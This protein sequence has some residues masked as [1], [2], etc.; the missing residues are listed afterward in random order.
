MNLGQLSMFLEVVR[1]GSLS[2]AARR[3]NLTQPAVTRKMQRL[4]KELGIALFERGEGHQVALTSMGRD[5]LAF[6]EKVIQDF[7]TLQESWRAQRHDVQGLL[8]LAASTTPGEFVVPRLLATFANRYPNVKPN[9]NILDSDE[10]E[11]RLL[12]G[13]YDAGFT[14][15]LPDAAQLNAHQI[16]LDEI[17]LAVPPGHRLAN[18][19]REIE[20]SELDGEILLDREQGSGTM[21]SVRRI[22]SESGK[23]L[24]PHKVMMTLGSTQAIISSVAAGL[25]SGFVSSLATEEAGKRVTALR[26]AGLPLKRS[27]YMIYD[28]ARQE[29]GSLLVREFLKFVLTGDELP[30]PVETGEEDE[31]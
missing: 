24:P 9:L 30:L 23:E 2:E 22:L 3:H 26:L 19:K 12:T 14:G 11:A 27:L 17:V 25:G 31:D 7:G 6:A 20:L 10:V 13:E 16:W 8:R 21:Q 4:E 18:G 5:F 28:Q 15:K 29:S 1:R